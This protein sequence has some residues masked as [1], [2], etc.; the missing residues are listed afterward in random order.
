MIAKRFGGN[1]KGAATGGGGSV[2]RKTHQQPKISTSEVDKKITQS[3]K[4]MNL[5]AIAAIE[6][7][8]MFKD[9]GE[10]I[11]FPN[12]KVQA[13]VQNRTFVISGD[14]ET[15]TVTALLPGILTQMGK[16]ISDLAS[17]LGG[18][19]GLGAPAGGDDDDDDDV[20]DLVDPDAEDI[21]AL[22]EEK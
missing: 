22:V 21:P 17:S 3:L 10:V 20:P 7:V 11:H 15:T 6:Q 4:K 1:V 13:A 14:C 16:E 12:P 5:Q 2:R 8:N 9:N 18:A 19:G